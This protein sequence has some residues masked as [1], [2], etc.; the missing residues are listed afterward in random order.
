MEIIVNNSKIDFQL[1][2]EKNALSTI[3][4]VK[5]LVNQYDKAYQEEGRGGQD[6]GDAQDALH[7]K[8]YSAVRVRS[9]KLAMDFS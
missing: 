5:K 2:D 4:G 1:D 9:M 6:G 8:W 3:E 7:Q